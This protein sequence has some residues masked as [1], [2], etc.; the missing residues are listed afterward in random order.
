M[1]LLNVSKIKFPFPFL[2]QW[3][4]LHVPLGTY[5]RCGHN[6]WAIYLTLLSLWFKPP[7]CTL[8]NK[9][10][11]GKGNLHFPDSIAPWLPLRF[12]QGKVTGRLECR[13]KRELFFPCFPISIALEIV[14]YTGNSSADNSLQ[15]LVS[16]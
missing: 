7:F 3:V 6:W 11:T 16:F 4:R 2:L 8:L 15:F 12:C 13:K 14:I 10:A 5:S 9:A 1:V